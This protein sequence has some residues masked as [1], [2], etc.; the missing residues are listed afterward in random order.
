MKLRL[1]GFTM[2]LLLQ[3]TN[4]NASCQPLDRADLSKGEK[5]YSV[6]LLG[7]PSPF[8]GFS[9]I[10]KI[11]RAPHLRSNSSD[12]YVLDKQ[13]YFEELQSGAF[14]WKIS[15]KAIKSFDGKSYKTGPLDIS[16]EITL[17]KEKRQS[18]LKADLTYSYEETF[19]WI[20]DNGSKEQLHCQN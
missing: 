11:H 20:L 17:L 13:S 8:Y 1:L 4:L 7:E 10:I 2:G 6:E 19:Y 16:P 5:L 3:N 9:E 14:I 15:Y 12:L 18:G